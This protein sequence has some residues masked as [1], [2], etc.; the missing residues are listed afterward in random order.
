MIMVAGKSA[1]LNMIVITMII[2]VGPDVTDVLPISYFFFKII[3]N[4]G[5]L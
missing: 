3:P 5:N 1:T 4:I 2:I